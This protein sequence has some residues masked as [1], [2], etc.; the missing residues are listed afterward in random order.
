MA[1]NWDDAAKSVQ[2]KPAS[3]HRGTGDVPATVELGREA[4]PALSR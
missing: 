2:A 4:L 3:P 1:Y